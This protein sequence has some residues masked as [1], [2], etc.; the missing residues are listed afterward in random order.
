MAT[1]EELLRTS[2]TQPNPEGHIVVGGDRFIRVPDNLKR[3]GVQYDHDIETVVFDC[4]RMW[5]GQDMSKMIVYINYVLSDGYMDKYRVKNVVADSDIMHFE[6]TISRNVTQVPGAVSFIVCITKTDGDNEVLHWNSEICTDC[7]ISKGME[8]EESDLI[9]EPDLVTRLLQEVDDI[10]EINIKSHEIQELLDETQSHANYAED[11]KNEAADISNYI[12]NSYAPAIKGVASGKVI[13]VDDVS[14]IE[15]QVQYLV[16]GK[17]LMNHSALLNEILEPQDSEIRIVEIDPNNGTITTY[18]GDLYNGNG[19]VNTS[20]KLKELCPQMRVG[21]RY[22]L[23]ATTDAWNKCMYL[24]GI[25]YFWNFGTTITIIEEM[26][27]CT[28]GFYG[29]AP[30]RGQEPGYCAISEF[31]I[32]EA[33]YA[34]EFVPY[35]DPTT[36]SVTKC[37]KNLLRLTGDKSAN[38]VTMLTYEGGLVRVYG[39]ST[40]AGVNMHVGKVFMKAGCKYKPTTGLVSGNVE[41]KYWDESLGIQTYPDSDGLLSSTVDT[42]LTVFIYAAGADVTFNARFKPMI[43]LVNDNIDDTFELYSEESVVPAADGGCI[44][45]S[46]SPTMTIYTDTPGI[47]VE[48]EYNRD[49]TKMFESYVLTDNAKDEIANKVAKDMVD[50]L[51][52]LNEYV[53]TLIEGG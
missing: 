16:R 32:E 17:N 13:R 40:N 22:T 50:V 15:H 27:N 24:S 4:P 49:T 31:Q 3:L 29:Y 44:T 38:G 21:R 20:V 10:R 42:T 6:W 8:T 39:T 12:K 45:T 30:Y 23:S 53:D 48:A 41:L 43:Q 25:D 18:C 36:T 19:H 33:P 11:V 51:D 28:V 34:T 7:Y 5:D 35:I 2:V 14:P 52:A 46:R 26:L 47:I 9:T 1:A 37:G